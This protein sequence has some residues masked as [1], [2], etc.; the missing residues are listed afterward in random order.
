MIWVILLCV[1][2]K[3]LTSIRIELFFLQ[4]FCPIMI[5]QWTVMPPI[6]RSPDLELDSYLVSVGVAG[7]D[8][9]TDYNE[10]E[11]PLIRIHYKHLQERVSGMH[12]SM[13]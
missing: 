8:T 6:D 1:G 13:A 12:L 9:D 5:Q 3:R 10:D 4:T 7:A 11:V 2:N